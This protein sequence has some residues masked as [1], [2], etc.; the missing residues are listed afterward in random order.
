LVEV[1]VNV[2]VSGAVP[3][4]ALVVKEATGASTGAVTV[5]VVLARWLLDPL[6]ATSVTL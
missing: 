3:E 2:I 6:L 5:I 4:T 1:L